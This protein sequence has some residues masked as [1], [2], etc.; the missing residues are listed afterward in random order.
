MQ[1]PKVEIIEKYSSKKT[2]QDLEVIVDKN[3]EP[4]ESMKGYLNKFTK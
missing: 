2:N 3:V 1:A 4:D